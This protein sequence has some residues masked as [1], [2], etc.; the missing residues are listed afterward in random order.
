MNAELQNHVPRQRWLQ[1]AALLLTAVALAACTTMPMVKRTKK[2]ATTTRPPVTAPQP[3]TRALPGEGTLQNFAGTCQQTDIDGFG[4]NATLRVAGGQVQQLDWHVKVGK[5][6]QCHFNLRDFRQTKNAPHIELL[7][8]SRGACK[9]L[10]YQD[11]R[12]VTLAHANCQSF[13]TPRSV[14]EEAWPV[15][16]NPQT[17][18]CASLNR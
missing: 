13:C 9:L 6:G 1:R 2:P 16:F 18:R 3:A 5:R 10:I 17:G 14:A 15:M 12:R 7:S 11:A 8:R 4:E